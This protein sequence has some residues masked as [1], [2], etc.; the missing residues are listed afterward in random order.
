M[1]SILSRHPLDNTGRLGLSMLTRSCL[2]VSRLLGHV[3][4]QDA[5]C[6]AVGSLPSELH[7]K[8]SDELGTSEEA[9]VLRLSSTGSNRPEDWH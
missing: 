7:S 3:Y 6:S 5:V 2:E 8:F 4:V 1:A 9:A